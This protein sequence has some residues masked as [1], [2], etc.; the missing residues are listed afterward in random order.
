M[1]KRPASVF[2]APMFRIHKTLPSPRGGCCS[3]GHHQRVQGVLALTTKE[4]SRGGYCPSGPGLAL[5][6]AILTQGSATPCQCPGP[7]WRRRV[8]KQRA[9]SSKSTLTQLEGKEKGWL[10]TDACPYQP[11]TIFLHLVNRMHAPET[12]QTCHL[13]H[14]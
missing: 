12:R 3:G 4:R 13:G 5:A 7:K 10:Q 11:P 9:S 14:C 1:S 2:I 8:L 6:A